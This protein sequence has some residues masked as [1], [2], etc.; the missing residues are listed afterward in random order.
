[1]TGHFVICIE[2]YFMVFELPKRLNICPLYP[3]LLLEW[4]FNAVRQENADEHLLSSRMMLAD[5]SVIL[6]LCSRDGDFLG[7][8]KG[9]IEDVPQNVEEQESKFADSFNPLYSFSD[10]EIATMDR[11][12]EELMDDE[13]SSGDENNDE[14]VKKNEESLRRKVLGCSAPQESSSEDSLSADFPRGWQAKKKLQKIGRLKSCRIGMGELDTDKEDDG[15]EGGEQDDI[16]RNAGD[17]SDDSENSE[18]SYDSVGSV[19]DDIALAVEKEF[20]S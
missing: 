12:V 11:E 5:K 19:D 20:L 15:D 7:K 9:C 8:E 18:K 1:M 6:V 4:L 2:L 13:D 10:E 3:H 17:E 16:S 14:N